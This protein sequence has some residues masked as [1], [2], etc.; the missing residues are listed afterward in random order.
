MKERCIAMGFDQDKV[1]F[2]FMTPVEKC[3]VGYRCFEPK[4]TEHCQVTIHIRKKYP[5]YESLLLFFFFASEIL[6][7]SKWKWWYKNK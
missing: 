2:V 5:C 1:K 3:F 6:Y 7:T 4:N